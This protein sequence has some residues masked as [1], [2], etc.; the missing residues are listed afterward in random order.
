MKYI[1]KKKYVEVAELEFLVIKD[2]HLH[3]SYAQPTVFS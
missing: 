1:K 2:N 3:G